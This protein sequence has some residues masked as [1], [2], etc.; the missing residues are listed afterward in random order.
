MA[1]AVL[2]TRK[3][4]ICQLARAYGRRSV[5]P[6]QFLVGEVLADHLRH[7]LGHHDLGVVSEEVVAGGELGDIAVEVLGGDVVVGAA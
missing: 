5:L 4:L 1:G 7:R 2:P 3:S 6:D